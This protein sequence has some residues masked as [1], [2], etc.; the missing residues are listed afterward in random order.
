MHDAVIHNKG[1]LSRVV[2]SHLLSD[3]VRSRPL[4]ND[5]M[6]IP[7]VITDDVT[8]GLCIDKMIYTFL[9]YTTAHKK[10]TK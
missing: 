10:K 2:K 1:Y 7:N 3:D 5:V 4:R 8:Q 6:F 9:H